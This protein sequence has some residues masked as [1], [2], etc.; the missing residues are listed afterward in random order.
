MVLKV[1]MLGLNG[2][3]AIAFKIDLGNAP[4]IIV[5]ASRGYIMCGYLNPDMAEKLGDVAVIVSGVREIEEILE[6]P[7]KWASSKARALG[8][9]EGM[10]GRAAL[11]KI[12]CTD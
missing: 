1:K 9:K 4:L 7:V 10:N 2:I 6:K 12:S 11:E 8:V 5:K 3:T